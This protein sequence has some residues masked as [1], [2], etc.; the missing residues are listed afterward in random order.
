MK[1]LDRVRPGWE[2][3][4]DL[5]TLDVNEPYDCVLGQ[6]FRGVSTRTNGAFTYGFALLQQTEPMN[7]A[8]LFAFGRDANHALTNEW[9]A[10]IRARRALNEARSV[11][12]DLG[13]ELPVPTE[14]APVLELV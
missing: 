6:V 3:F 11:R 9:K 8:T 7:I 1:M 5:D 13:A 2:R 4:I 12:P 14:D 10:H